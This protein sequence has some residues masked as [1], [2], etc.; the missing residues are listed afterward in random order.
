MQTTTM[1]DTRHDPIA[2]LQ[3][4]AKEVRGLPLVVLTQIMHRNSGGYLTFEQIF[5]DTSIQ[6]RANG[7][8]LTWET[9][10]RDFV[11]ALHELIRRGL[12]EVDERGRDVHYS[13]AL[14]PAQLPW[15]WD[16]RRAR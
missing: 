7:Q 11:M 14:A 3:A 15:L 16:R 2:R 4:Q 9:G 13:L 5:R 8:P 10:H 6:C 12:V 1:V